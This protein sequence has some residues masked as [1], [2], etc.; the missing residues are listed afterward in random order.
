MMPAAVLFRG[1]A[2]RPPNDGFSRRSWGIDWRLCLDSHRRFLLDPLRARHGELDVFLCYYRT[3]HAPR[4]EDDY[5]ATESVFAK[6]GA[7]QRQTFLHGLRIVP[8]AY[9]LIATCRFDVELLVCPL[10]WGTFRPDAINFLFREWNAEMWAHHRR[11][12]DAL[13]FLPGSLL[14]G[15]RKGVAEAPSED[16]LHI[17]HDPVAR[18]VG[19]DR[20]HVMDDRYFDSN[21]ETPPGNPVYNLV[22]VR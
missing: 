13:H 21:P 20:V 9:D 19:A 7:S 22:R 17:V 4:V 1:H 2:H 12:A 5:A 10:D 8:A 6:P 15:F 3:E 18:H 11:V 14:D 16:C